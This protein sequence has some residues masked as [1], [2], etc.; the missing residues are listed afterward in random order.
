MDTMDDTCLAIRSDTEATAIHAFTG[1]GMTPVT[2]TTTQASTY[3]TATI[4]TTS[5]VTMIFIEPATRTHT[6]TT[7]HG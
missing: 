7:N 4:S 1:R 5:Q 6:V 3:A 2:M